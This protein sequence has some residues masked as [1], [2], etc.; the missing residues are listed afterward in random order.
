MLTHGQI[1]DAIDGL[2][3]SHG[4]SASGL[5]RRAGLDPTTFNRSKRVAPDGRL[6]WPSTESI[7]KVLD[8]TGASLHEFVAM[9]VGEAPAA[10]PPRAAAKPARAGA[11]PKL[12]GIPLIGMAQ[13]G[14]G[15]YYDDS[16]YPVGGGFDEVIF[17]RP[18]EGA[19]YGL[20]V[21]GDS[22][23]PVYRDGD[24]IVVD[25]AATAHRGDRV[26]AR[27]RDGEVMAKELAL[28]T[29]KLVR[30]RSLNP[31]HPDREFAPAELDWIARIIWAS[32]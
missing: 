16:G 10:A 4:L 19:L 28:R 25:P 22:M 21:A 14:Q 9:A 20:K 11:P 23:L 27:T 26:V 13:A 24:I 32:Q 7:A 2:A 12:R 5:A 18:G 3:R 30:L 31:E 1:W 6:R 15:G 8:A 17:P 29:P